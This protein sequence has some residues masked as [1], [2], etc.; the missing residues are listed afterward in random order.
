M[1]F[2]DFKNALA[3]FSIFSLS[4]IRAVDDSFDRRRL[5]EWQKKG[6]IRKIIKGH[7]LFSDVKIDEE[8]LFQIANK[9]YRPSY[10]SFETALSY[11]HLIPES[12]YA[13]TSA[14]SKRTYE[15][16]TSM[17]RFLY[18]R[19]NPKLFF[20]YVLI[21]DR[22]RIASLEKTV[23]DYFYLNTSIRTEDDFASIRI[24][25]DTFLEQLN[26]RNMFGYLQQFRQKKLTE[27][28]K[29]FMEWIKNA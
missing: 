3:D 5:S 18:R 7:Y 11:Y 8:K 9:I 4:D 10:I 15:F 16:Q 22:I 20:G 13:I 29:Y 6:Y 14:S 17:S 19:I 21:S 26:E 23:L 27:R 25:R 24:D 1:N 28:I 2:I 12:V